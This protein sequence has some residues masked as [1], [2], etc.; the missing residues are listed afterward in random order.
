M[1]SPFTE[2]EENHRKVISCALTFVIWSTSK[3][4][5][6]AVREIQL[7][8]VDSKT[9]NEAHPESDPQRFS[10]EIVWKENWHDNVEEDKQNF[11][12]STL[13]KIFVSWWKAFNLWSYLY[14]N[15]M[16]LSALMSFMSMRCIS[17][18]QSGW[19]ERQ[20]QPTWAKKKPRR[21]FNGSLTVSAYLWWT[22][23][24]RTQL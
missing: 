10:K 21:K 22:R 1:H 15:I 23:W 19:K 12:V 9:K 8:E 6:R 20:Y 4:M 7:S 2:R 3:E 17:F 14:W 24:T 16:S 11:V 5:I 13:R 18:S